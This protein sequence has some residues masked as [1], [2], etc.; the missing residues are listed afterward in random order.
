MEGKTIVTHN[1]KF[2]TDDVF[3]VA[4]LKLVFGKNNCKVVRT[5]D[6]EKI[7]NADIVVDVGG[8]YNKDKE[9]YDHHQK[10]GA[11]VRDNGIPYASFGLVWKK[12]GEKVCGGSKRIA[13]ILDKELVQ[14]IDAGDNG[15]DLFSLNDHG[16]R[17]ILIS[18]V[19]DSYRLTWQEGQDG[20]GEQFMKCVDWAMFML[21]RRIAFAKAFIDAEQTVIDAYEQSEDKRIIILDKKYDFGRELVTEILSRYKEPLFTVLYRS[22]VN[23]WQAAAIRK[24]EGFETRKTF[25]D[26]WLGKR[27]GELEEETRV[28]DAVFCHRGGFMCIAQSKE[29]AVALAQK[30]ILS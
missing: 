23:N 5:R 18:D 12:Y 9:R 17:P 1:G 30:A 24:G 19:V 4:A 21:N 13:E 27:D 11:G 3:A 26:K 28:E 8:E 10:G 22:D 6:E 7:K 16:V 20:W 2:H 15:V 14:P 25:P 29:G